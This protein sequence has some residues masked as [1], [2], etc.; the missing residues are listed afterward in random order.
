MDQ[1]PSSSLP[2][3]S[4]ALQG[5][6]LGRGRFAG[7]A[8]SLLVHLGLGGA[9]VYRWSGPSPAV[10]LSPPPLVVVELTPLPKAPERATNFASRHE[11]SPP[12]AQPLPRSLASLQLQMPPLALAPLTISPPVVDPG[13]IAPISHAFALPQTDAPPPSV[14]DGRE[15][16]EGRLLARIRQVRRY[17]QDALRRRLEGTVQMRFRMDRKGRVLDVNI[18]GSSG[19][20]QLDQEALATIVRAQPLPEI[21]KGRPD[22]IVIT[23]PIEFFLMDEKQWAQADLDNRQQQPP[24]RKEIR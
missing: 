2:A 15:T 4:S 20:R 10:A 11:P 6:W 18:V 14:Q 13:P 17:P 7:V 19:V 8:L 22:L 21:P 1:A 16:F 24:V 12:V 5:R 3:A 9:L 23:V